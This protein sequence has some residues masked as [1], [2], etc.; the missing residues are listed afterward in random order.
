MTTEKI[1]NSNEK[2]KQNNTLAGALEAHEIVALHDL[3]LP[4]FE[5]NR[6]IDEQKALVFDQKFRYDIILG[7][8]FL[9]KTGIDVKYSTG[10][11]KWFESKILLRDPFKMNEYEVM[12]MADSI[13]VQHDDAFIG[14]EWLDSYLANPILDAKYEKMEIPAMVAEMAHLNDAQKRDLK[15]LLLKYKKLFD[16]TL[17]VYPH[18]KV[19]IELEED[20][21]PVHVRPYAVPRVHYETFKKELR[22]LVKIGVLSEQESSEWALPSFIAPKKDG[23]VR[24]ISDLRALNKVIKHKQWP[25]PI[26]SK[27]LKKR[28][29][30]AFFTKLDIS[31]QY[32][33]FE[34]DKESKDLCTIITPFGKFK[35]N[36]LPM[37]LKYSPDFAQEMME[38]LL[39]DIEDTDV[40]IDVLEC[41]LMIRRYTIF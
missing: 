2:T 29:G 19:H 22:H 32:Y 27:V 13:E 17:G 16:G 23:R 12:V 36:R 24:W 10:V 40:Y 25:L 41:I 26:I 8:N 9:Q 1:Y 39:Q 35:Y 28:S 4:E 11:V 30:Y 37:G 21:K 34:L 18:K 33:T 20:A 5:N 14:K 6:I 31:M 15:K 3:R 38:N 7:T